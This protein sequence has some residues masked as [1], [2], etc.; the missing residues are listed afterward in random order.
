MRM[1]GNGYVLAGGQSRRMGTDKSF[2][3]WR[4]R[5][6]IERART[7]LSSLHL[8][9][10]VVCGSPGQAQRH[11]GPTVV[12]TIPDCGPMGGILAGLR[13]SRERVNCFVPCDMPLLTKD[14]LISLSAFACDFDI[15]VPSD[16]S[17]YPQP[18][19]GYYSSGC[20]R[21]IEGRIQQGRLSLTELIESGQV[22]VKIVAGMAKDCGED[23]FLN[24]NDPQALQRTRDRKPDKRSCPAGFPRRS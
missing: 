3:V 20:I 19:V 13:H 23:I 22:R 5:P 8:E 9:V 6:L 2:L 21:P 24:V 17:G 10:H 7:L 14:L 15:V 4:G 16:A 12:D 18:V 1:Q 11:L